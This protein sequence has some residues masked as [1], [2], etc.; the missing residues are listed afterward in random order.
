M[1]KPLEDTALAKVL[2]SGA[3]RIFGCMEAHGDTVIRQ[4]S[5]EGF[6][7]EGVEFS[8]EDMLPCAYPLARE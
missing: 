2:L 4:P 3:K 1:A 7:E 8:H 6:E 5:S